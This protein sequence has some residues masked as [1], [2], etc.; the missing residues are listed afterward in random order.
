MK[1][2]SYAQP[3]TF[4]SSPDGT[5]TGNGADIDGLLQNALRPINHKHLVDHDLDPA[6]FLRCYGSNVRQVSMSASRLDGC[7]LLSRMK[8]SAV[9]LD[10]WSLADLCSLPNR[11]LSWLANPL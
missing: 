9:W 2:E 7:R 8:Q 3:S 11:L 6:A 5:T 1:D 4:L 10:W